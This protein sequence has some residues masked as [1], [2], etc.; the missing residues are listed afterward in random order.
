MS[1]EQYSTILSVLVLLLG[2]ATFLS[3]LSYYFSPTTRL[4]VSQVS[5]ETWLKLIAGLATLATAGALTY[6]YHYLL[7]VCH[8]CWWQRIFMFPIELIIAVSLYTKSKTNHLI[9]AIM[10]G[11]GLPISLYHY[12]GHYQK[13]VA[14]NPFLLPCSTNPLEASCSNSPIV[15]FGFITIPFMAAI[16]FVALLWLSHLAFKKSEQNGTLS[17]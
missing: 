11:I 10:A 2:T 17:Q 1:L 13:Y 3:I 5:Y 16:V 12:Y 7:P 15:T 14:G 9:V 8:L 4:I 6:Q